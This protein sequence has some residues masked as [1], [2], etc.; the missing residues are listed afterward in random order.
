MSVQ[1]VLSAAGNLVNST[2]LHRGVVKKQL[3][4]EIFGESSEEYADQRRCCRDI[5]FSFNQ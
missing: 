5:P 2:D 3:A 1:V 4:L